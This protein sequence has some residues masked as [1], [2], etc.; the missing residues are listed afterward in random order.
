MTKRGWALLGAILGGAIGAAIA[1]RLLNGRFDHPGDWRGGAARFFGWAT[2]LGLVAGYA[3]GGRLARAVP[4]RRDGFRLSFRRIDPEAAGYRNLT[5]LAVADLVAAL[6]ASGYEPYTEGCDSLGHRVGPI[7]L[8]TPLAGAN[9]AISDPGVRGWIRVQ[10][11][12]PIDGAP[13]SLG[14]IEMWPERGGSAEELGS[15]ALRALDGLLDELTAAP[16]SSM[17]GED[18]ASL[19]TAGL[20]DRPRHRQA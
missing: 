20:P 12:P 3:V 2:A 4:A 10:L 9:V 13:R 8:R 17:L 16:E 7:D 5:T 15:F 1:W 19:V 14:L 11:A 18:P 6:T